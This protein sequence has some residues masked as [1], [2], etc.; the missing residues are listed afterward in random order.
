VS[1]FSFWPRGAQRA[2]SL[3][4]RRQEPD[5]L[6]EDERSIFAHGEIDAERTDRGAANLHAQ[7]R[8]AIKRLA[9]FIRILLEA[10]DNRAKRAQE[11]LTAPLERSTPLQL[12]YGFGNDV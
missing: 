5:G 8:Q 9:E 1:F 4:P 3:L 10:I 2:V 7:D 12:P 11:F 6:D